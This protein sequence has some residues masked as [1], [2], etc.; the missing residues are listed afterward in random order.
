MK[1]LCLLL[2]LSTFL[3]AADEPV[4]IDMYADSEQV[5]IGDELQVHI[6]YSWPEDWT[7]DAAP[8]PATVFSN[9]DLFIVDAPPK[10]EM[11]DGGQRRWRW[12]FTVL[13]KQSG[14][15]SLPRPGIQVSDT[16]GHTHTAT[17]P[18]LIIQVGIDESP[19]R[20]SAPSPSWTS[21]DSADAG[22]RQRYWLWAVIA[23]IL[24]I[25][26]FML[27]RLRRRQDRPTLSAIEEFQQTITSARKREDG[28]DAAALLSQAVRRFCGRCWSFDGAA[29]TQREMR[30]Y[31]NQ[32]L[33]PDDLRRIHQVLDQLE[34]LRWTPASMHK[35]QVETLID[36]A[37]QWCTEQ[38]ARLKAAAEAQTQ[39]AA[40]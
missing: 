6:I 23:L 30:I 32:N 17:A 34:S 26:S 15:W 24:M 29:A 14:A 18:E 37:A 11:I 38:D 3:A 1:A 9:S 12:Q 28:K 22:L 16:E 19:P 27:W 39:E 21:A 36:A 25:G 13:A 40:A 35:E 10:K 2:L 8:D 20:L 4:R 5:T 31:L 7:P 33:D